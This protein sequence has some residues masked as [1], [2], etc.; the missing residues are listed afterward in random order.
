MSALENVMVG[1][2]M[3]V[4]ASAAAQMFWLPAARGEERRLAERAEALLDLAGLM[5]FRDVAA[6]DLPMGMQKT[7]EIMR[8]LMAR[9]RMLLLDEPAAGLNDSETAELAALLMAI[10]DSAITIIVVEHNMS[11]VMGIADR[12]AVLDAGRLVAI[13]TPAEIRRDRRVIEA[14]VG[15]EG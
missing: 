8:A 2:H 10:R 9:P 5:E 6:V 4:R 3:H 12:V 1:A 7:L 15:L 14:Y 13:G 11:L